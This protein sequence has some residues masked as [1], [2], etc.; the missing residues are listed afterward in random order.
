[1]VVKAHWGACDDGDAHGQASAMGVGWAH[2]R[3]YGFLG[4]LMSRPFVR[5]FGG[6]TIDMRLR[7]YVSRWA[8]VQPTT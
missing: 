5:G 6:M 8:L 3:T 7:P 1:M 2:A 4:N